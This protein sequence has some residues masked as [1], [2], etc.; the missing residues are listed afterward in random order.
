MDWQG[1]LNLIG[2]YTFCENP[3]KIPQRKTA[4][5]LT[6]CFVLIFILPDLSEL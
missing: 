6:V 5:I 1:M 3:A 4:L 2:P